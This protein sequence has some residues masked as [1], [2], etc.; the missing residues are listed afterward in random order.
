MPLG[1]VQRLSSERQRPVVHKVADEQHENPGYTLQLRA[2]GATEGGGH[3]KGGL[4][5][6]DA[7]VPEVELGAEVAVHEPVHRQASL[8]LEFV[9]PLIQHQ[10]CVQRNPNAIAARGVEG[11]GE[12][13]KEGEKEG[14]KEGGIRTVAHI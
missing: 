7:G 8:L 4:A 6:V 1:T 9:P 3:G 5:G 12:G 13:G 10:K 11:R 14:E 2:K